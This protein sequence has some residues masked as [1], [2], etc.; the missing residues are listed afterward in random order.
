M[1]RKV[2]KSTEDIE[3]PIESENSGQLSG[4]D[5]FLIV[6]IVAISFGLAVILVWFCK[7]METRRNRRTK[8]GPAYLDNTT[9]IRN[10]A[11]GDE[12]ENEEELLSGAEFFRMEPPQN[13]EDQTASGIDLRNIV[14]ISSSS[15]TVGYQTVPEVDV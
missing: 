15:N 8:F 1:S 4:M 3:I 14:R 12:D 13:F 9:E 10:Y 2:P 6:A 7:R 5:D 11:E